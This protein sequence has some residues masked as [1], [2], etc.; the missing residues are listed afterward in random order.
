MY[1][2][3]RHIIITSWFMWLR[4]NSNIT[5]SL[6]RKQASFKN[7]KQYVNNSK[8]VKLGNNWKISC[9]NKVENRQVFLVFGLPFQPDLVVISSGRL[10]GMGYMVW[11]SCDSVEAVCFSIGGG[12]GVW[13]HS[14]YGIGN[15]SN[16]A[17]TALSRCDAAGHSCVRLRRKMQLSDRGVGLSTIWPNDHGV[18]RWEGRG[19]A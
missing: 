19:L 7:K 6:V 11:V 3:V 14:P 2:S 5:Y 8:F 17:W 9:I 15:G 10:S 13:V 4:W 16:A 18:L 1:W 12:T